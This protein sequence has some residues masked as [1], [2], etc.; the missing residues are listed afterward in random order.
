VTLGERLRELRQARGFTQ[1]EMAEALGMTR[2][3]Y[4][5]IESGKNGQS[6]AKLPII[7]K[8]LG[9]SI[10][11]LFPEMDAVRKSRRETR[12]RRRFLRKAQ[13]RS[14]E[15]RASRWV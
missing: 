14:T 8:K 11:R 3:G 7:A 13:Y 10:D 2:P 5:N 12:R 9:C 1:A 6:F 4:Y 15:R